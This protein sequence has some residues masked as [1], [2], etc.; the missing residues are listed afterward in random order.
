ME[1]VIQRLLKAPH[2]AGVYGYL[3]VSPAVQSLLQIKSEFHTLNEV[4]EDLRLIKSKHWIVTEKQLQSYG[5][6]MVT[7]EIVGNGFLKEI[8]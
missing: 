2:E 8:K 3:Y 5:T 6:P 1:E 7:Y 4:I